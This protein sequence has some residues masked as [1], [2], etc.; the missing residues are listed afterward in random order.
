MTRLFQRA[1]TSSIKLL[2]SQSNLK[3][4]NSKDPK[5]RTLKIQ[6]F[7]PTDI[8]YD[9]CAD[10]NRSEYEDSEL[11][12]EIITGI[13]KQIYIKYLLQRCASTSHLQNISIS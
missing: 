4:N 8:K 2:G 7:D 11:S 1:S 5:T 12:T 10:A 3:E 13:E 9:E 6:E